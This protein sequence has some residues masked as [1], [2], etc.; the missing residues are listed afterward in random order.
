MDH[1]F[2]FDK[3]RKRAELCPC[4]KSNR[5]KKFSPYKG[6]IDKGYCHAC[7]QNFFPEKETK[8]N[9]FVFN[10]TNKPKPTIERPIS[11]INLN[12]FRKSLAFYDANKFVTYLKTVFKP[13]LVDHAIDKYKIGTS[14][15]WKGATVFW[16][17]DELGNARTGKIMLYD[18]HTGKRVK[19]PFDHINWVHSVLKIDDYNLGQVFFGTHC[20]NSSSGTVAIVESEKTAIIASI[21]LPTVTWL[22]AGSKDGLKIEK[23]K[24]LKNRNIILYPDANAFELWNGFA[25]KH[26]DSFRI[27]VSSLIDHSLTD[28]KKEQG[29]DIADY[30]LKSIPDYLRVDYNPESLD[31]I[32]SIPAG[33]NTFQEY[34]AKN[35][36]LNSLVS[37]LNLILDPNPSDNC[38]WQNDIPSTIKAINSEIKPDTAYHIDEIKSLI[39]TYHTALNID[40]ENIIRQLITN[41]V[42][43]QNTLNK[44]CYY[45]Y[46]ST[47]F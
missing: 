5:D 38:N 8:N 14:K 4:G 37:R 3:N 16:Q 13:E 41:K 30:L 36:N 28:D 23:L 40:F 47:P 9:P 7:G 17:I 21:C 39:K 27:K 35:P 32:I 42:I 15:L 18:D 31:K 44:E 45:K 24:P 1:Q 12:V 22:A 34:I 11:F 10:H 46:G 20:I 33:S 26:K 25:I 43:V 6:Y 19:K 2:Q 29:E